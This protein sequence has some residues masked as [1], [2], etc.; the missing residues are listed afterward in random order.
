MPYKGPY[1]IYIVD[2]AEK[3]NAAAQN[4][5]LKTIEEPPE[6]AVIFLLDYE[7]RSIFRHNSFK[8]YSSCHE[9]RYPEQ[10]LRNTWWKNVAFLRK[11]QN[12]QQDFLL[13]I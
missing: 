13:E 3:M 7:Q 6:Y 10:L 1:K 8:M 5:I 11:K 4:A 2:E 9:D 12:L